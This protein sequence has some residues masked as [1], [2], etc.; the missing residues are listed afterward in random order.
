MKIRHLD[1]S[2]LPRETEAGKPEFLPTKGQAQQQRVDQQG[3]Q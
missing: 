3:K 1:P 2:I